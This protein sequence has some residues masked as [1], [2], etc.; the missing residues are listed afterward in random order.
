M[1]IYHKLKVALILIMWNQVTTS[2]A[3]TCSRDLSKV[4]RGRVCNPSCTSDEQCTKPLEKCLCDDVCGKSCFNPG[5][6]CKELPHLSSGLI[7]GEQRKYGSNV[8]YKCHENYI[9]NG[10]VH[11]TCRSDGKWTGITPKCIHVS[12]CGQAGSKKAYRKLIVGPVRKVVRGEEA[13]RGAWPWQ[14][15]LIENNKSKAHESMESLLGGGTIINKKWV[16]SAAHLFSRWLVIKPL[17]LDHTIFI[18]AGITRIPTPGSVLPQE[19]QVYR[20]REIIM[21]PL[22][23]ASNNDYDISLIRVGARLVPDETGFLKMN[24]TFPSYGF[25][26]DE[27]V[28]PLCLPCINQWRD[29]VNELSEEQ[30]FNEYS[31]DKCETSHGN[32]YGKM[33]IVTGFGVTR[34]MEEVP[35][36][37]AVKSTVLRQG[38]MEI[39]P[40]RIC[41]EGIRRIHRQYKAPQYTERMIC[42]RAINRAHLQDACSGDSGGPLMQKVSTNTGHE[43]WILVG[44]VSWGWGCA[45]KDDD[46][47]IF[48][49]YYTNFTY[50]ADWVYHK[51]AIGEYKWNGTSPIIQIRL[52]FHYRTSSTLEVVRRTI[53]V[54]TYSTINSMKQDIEYIDPRFAKAK[55]F[56]YDK[57]NKRLYSRRT[58]K[59]QGVKSGDPLLV[60]VHG[61]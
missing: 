57:N 50:F 7:F 15:M 27:Y 42:A 31:D 19:M 13:G 8:Y 17:A 44:I 29:G 51:T 2:C 61:G 14:V 37:W 45:N 55:Q 60:A 36:F 24:S 30:K 58:L 3:K 38:Y 40:N 52:F 11:R 16:L 10:P 5:L 26:F 43:Y 41:Q 23:N 1:A 9:L 46:G 18:V 22:F 56:I 49:G 12:V 54:D 39:L 48:P 47:F 4:E 33:S 34:P 35:T 53:A 32:L 21:H 28:R 59:S 25:T 20:P 6:K